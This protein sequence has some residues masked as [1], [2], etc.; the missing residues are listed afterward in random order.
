MGPGGSE[1]GRCKDADFLERIAWCGVVGLME[2]LS[3]LNVHVKDDEIFVAQSGRDF[4]A[5]YQK[6]KFDSG[7]V[8]EYR[9]YG[10]RGFLSSAWLAA[11]IKAREL[12][13]TV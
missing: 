4:F 7:I 3:K 6:A 12:G 9:F 13:W 2:T 1:A 5:I 10:P 11:N 8:A